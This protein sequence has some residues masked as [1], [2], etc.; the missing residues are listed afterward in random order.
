MGKRGGDGGYKVRGRGRD[1]WYEVRERGRKGGI[2]R[3]KGE[4]MGCI[5]W[6]GRKVAGWLL[7]SGGRGRDGRL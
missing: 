6:G 1:W 5:E 3:W 2:K 7:Y 4:G